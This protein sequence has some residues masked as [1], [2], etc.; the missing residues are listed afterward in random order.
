VS[1]AVERQIL[2]GAP[3]RAPGLGARTP[4]RPSA[5]AAGALLV[6]LVLEYV[7]PPG[8]VQLKLQMLFVLLIPV[9]WLQ[10]NPKPWS[11]NLTLQLALV[12]QAALSIAYANNWFSAWVRTRTHFGTFAVALA[13]TW[14]LA[15]RRNFERTV[16]FWVG[17]MSYQAIYSFLHAGRGSGGFIGDEND[18]AL[19]CA[20][21]FPFVYA[22][23][24][25]SKR[26][27]ICLLMA[28]LY[29]ASI[30]VSWSRGGFLGLLAATLYCVL[31]G[32]HKVR[33]IAIGVLAAFAFYLALPASYKAELE[34][35]QETD[36]GTSEGRF[37]LWRAA[38][39]MWLDHP[40]QGVGAGNGPWLIGRY[41][42]R[43]VEG[44][45]FDRPMYMHRDWSGT[46]VHSLYFELLSEN[47]LIGVAIFLAVVY[48]QFTGLH[49]LR[50]DVVRDSRASPELRRKVDLYVTGLAGATVAYL[51]AGAFLSVLYYPYLWYF[52]A[53]AVALDRWVRSDLAGPLPAPAPARP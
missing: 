20:T 51:V 21:V 23:M 43:E 17:I 29:A 9:L 31:V 46:V 8:I 36:E 27:V 12:A 30:V 26:R 45:L 38:T 19:A 6:F 22:G 34:T 52:S 47:G 4:A 1:T 18:L 32:R 28:I 42:P 39:N 7:R 16:W 41:Q 24:L 11:R 48:L 37:F 10:L 50:R 14:L 2:V 13:I 15:D 53:M 49:R 25:Y 3:G 5:F 35:I 33:N 40:I 44:T